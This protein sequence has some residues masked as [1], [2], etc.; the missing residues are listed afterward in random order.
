[1]T[2]LEEPRLD[3][4]AVSANGTV[5]PSAKPIMMSRIMSAAFEWF[6]A[7]W[8]AF[9][10]E[11]AESCPFSAEDSERGREAIALGTPWGVVGFLSLFRSILQ[12]YNG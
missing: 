5:S 11:L 12:T 1:M 2:S 4:P 9:S 10:N 8:W 7:S 3:R 6:S